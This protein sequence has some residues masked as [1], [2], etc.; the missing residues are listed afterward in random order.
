MITTEKNIM[1]GVVIMFF[2]ITFFEYDN[3]ISLLYL[4]IVMLYILL[5]YIDILKK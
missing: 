1:H 4:D 2:G 3:I 5:F